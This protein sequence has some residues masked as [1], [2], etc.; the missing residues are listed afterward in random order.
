MEPSSSQAVTRRADND[1]KQITVKRHKP[2][3]AL[4]DPSVPVVISIEKLPVEIL[5]DIFE[6]FSADTL[7]NAFYNLNATINTIIEQHTP[8]HFK[9]ARD[10]QCSPYFNRFL[11]KCNPTH[12]T[13]L[14][15][16]VL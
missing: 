5:I 10:S 2:L 14:R 1:E 9:F 16:H 7:V 15:L 13:S 12:V 8:L 3:S 11:L 4:V 6:F